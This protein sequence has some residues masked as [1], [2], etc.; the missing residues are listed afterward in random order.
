M[1]A[2]F[3]VNR[4]F[5]PPPLP[6]LTELPECTMQIASE[7]RVLDQLVGVLLTPSYT[8]IASQVAM[9]GLLCLAYH[10]HA[11]PHLLTQNIISAVVEACT[12]DRRGLQPQDKQQE[13]ELC[14]D[15]LLLR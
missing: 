7:H 9:G 11:H 4:T 14:K 15:I 3:L 8:P 1:I 2:I 6:S 12:R 10:P 13:G 5:S